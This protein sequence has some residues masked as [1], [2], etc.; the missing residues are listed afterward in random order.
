MYMYYVSSPNQQKTIRL[1]DEVIM[2]CNDDEN[3]DE[4][5][6]EYTV[7]TVSKCLA[8]MKACLGPEFERSIEEIVDYRWDM[9]ILSFRFLWQASTRGD[10]PIQSSTWH[11]M[12]GGV[13]IRVNRLKPR[14]HIYM[15]TYTEH[16]QFVDVS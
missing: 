5:Y 7:M 8:R 6:D 14:A 1:T 15:Y 4:N 12:A 2:W 3:Y 16:A 9:V 13:H 10:F 11:G